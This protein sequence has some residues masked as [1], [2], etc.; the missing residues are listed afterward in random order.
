MGRR[1]L[2]L[3][4]F[5]LSA[6]APSS[7]K[8]QEKTW[9]KNNSHLFQPIKVALHKHF[10]LTQHTTHL[11]MFRGGNSTLIR[12]VCATGILNLSP[13][14]G[15]GKPKKDTLLWSYRSLLY[16]IVL[17]CIVLYCIVL[18]CIVLYCIVLYCIVLYCI[19][20]YCI[21]LYCI[22]SY[23]IVLYCIVSEK[24]FMFKLYLFNQMSLPFPFSSY[25]VCTKEF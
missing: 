8:A 2:F 25:H 16:C 3:F 13:C 14:S 11:D 5:R 12:R 22:V 10:R 15:V 21:V 1:I 17:Y 20:L 4:M 23:C 18:C 7:S 9:F 24:K 6:C 19:V